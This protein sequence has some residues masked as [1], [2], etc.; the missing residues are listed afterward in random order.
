V[1][2][3]DPKP[4]TVLAA[5]SLRARGAALV[6]LSGHRLEPV[7]HAR[8]VE[9]HRLPPLELR[10]E[11]WSARLLELAARL[12]PRPA[13]FACST[14]AIALL[15][16]DRARLEPHFTLANLQRL[17]QASPSIAP[18][19][20][21]RQALLRGDAALEVQMVRDARG[22]RLGHCILAWAPGAPP[23]VLVTSVEGAEVACRS[24]DWLAARR[25]VG[26]ARLVW[27][28][29]RFGRLVLQ[30]AGVLPG[31]SADLAQADGVDFAVLSYA[32][33]TS[34]DIAPE[35]PRCELVRRLV[36]LE[37]GDDDAPLV[38]LPVRFDLRDPL[39][40]FA[41]LARGFFVQPES[42]PPRAQ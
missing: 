17:E 28:P 13:V 26:Y 2:L 40:W 7:L 15:R 35:R 16:G 30:A 8:G 3:V 4:W 32:A 38:T 18:D 37:P 22:T 29:D 12:E 31:P 34:W 41:S 1:V 39:P 33:A 42:P 27:A 25:F 14:A 9:R 24:E 36:V 19:A 20:A 11:R 23:D 6:A 5:R 10:P 21:L